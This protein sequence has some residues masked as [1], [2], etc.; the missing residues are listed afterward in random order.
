[1]FPLRRLLRLAG[2]RWRYSNPPPHGAVPT[3]NEVEV[4]VN[5]RPSQ[6]ASLSWCQALIWDPRQFFFLLEISLRQLRV[7]YFV[8]PSLTRGRVCNL[9]YNCFWALPE[10]QLLGRS[11]AEFTAIFYLS[12]LRL[13]QP[14]GRGPRIY[15]PQEQGGPVI[16]PGTGFPFCRLL[17]LAGL[18]WRY[19]NP[20]PHEAPTANWSWSSCGRQSVDQ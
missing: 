18:W 16:P 5:L 2:L 17:R 8:A 15:I 10:Q 20:P 3:A 7:C 4:E 11:P 14:G 6:S 9:L 13:P 12:H 1:V 19:S